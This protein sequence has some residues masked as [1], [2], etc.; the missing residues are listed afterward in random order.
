MLFNFESFVTAELEKGNPHFEEYIG[1]YGEFHPNIKENTFYTEYVTRFCPPKFVMQNLIV[2]EELKEDYDF[3][4]LLQFLTSSCSSTYEFLKDEEGIELC[5]HVTSQGVS[6][7]KKISELWSFQVLTLF[8]IYL[9]EAISFLVIKHTSSEEEKKLIETHQKKRIEY[10]ESNLYVMNQH[11][12][13]GN[14]DYLKGI[15]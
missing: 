3:T 5:I 8:E 10:F 11:F 15:V 1:I 2:P 7:T 6:V 14:N 9:R 13:K 12:E 4:L